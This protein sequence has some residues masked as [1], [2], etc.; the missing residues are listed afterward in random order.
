MSEHNTYAIMPYEDYVEVCDAIRNKNGSSALIKSG[1]MAALINGDG[2]KVVAVNT[3]TNK[4]YR[5]VQTALNGALEGEIIAVQEDV[6]IGTI[7]IPMNATLDLNGH[8][9]NA[10]HVACNGNII[11]SSAENTGVLYVPEQNFLIQKNNVQLPVKNGDGYSFFEVIKF[12]ETFMKSNKK[13]AFQPFVESSAHEL[14]KCG[15]AISGVSV[16]TYRTGFENGK[17]DYE[18]YYPCSDDVTL[19]VL[20][21]YDSSTNKYGQMYAMSFAKIYAGEY[22]VLIKSKTGVEF[23]SD[24]VN[25]HSVTNNL[26]GFVSSNSEDAIIEGEAYNATLT[27][28]LSEENY[29]TNVSITMDNVDITSEVY[30]STTGAISIP[31]VT[32]SVI[33]TAI[34]AKVTNYTNLFNRF[35]SGFDDQTS[36]FY[37]NWIPYNSADNDGNGTIYHFKGFA[38]ATTPYKI[39]FATDANGTNA[40]SQIYGTAL[41]RQART[42]ASYDSKVNIIQHYIEGYNYIRFEC[43]EAVP[44]NFVITANEGIID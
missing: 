27:V 4:E 26:L 33:I 6:S 44:S 10:N 12:N 18:T 39:N 29:T 22:H 43:R 15:S 1:E 31:S 40:T 9:V 38:N 23:L 32:G 7:V 3:T 42:V 28:N 37:T 30:D 35:A 36:K 5:N 17:L 13:Y 2:D 16:Y 11:D 19:N 20:N 41:N 8:A 14:L 25:I 34:A 24:G 21:S